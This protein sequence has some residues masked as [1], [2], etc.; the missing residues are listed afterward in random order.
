M[1]EE[2]EKRCS[3]CGSAMAFIRRE[4]I[5]LGEASVLLGVWPNIRAGA[6][7]VELWGCPRCGKLD[8]YRGDL[9]EEQEEDR[10]AQTACPACGQLHDLD[11]PKCPFCGAKN[12]NI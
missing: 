12:P 4:D 7:D 10:M 1:S 8:L 2:M 11:D 9:F 6:L 5:Q 3:N